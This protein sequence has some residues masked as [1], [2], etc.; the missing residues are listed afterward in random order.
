MSLEFRL[1]CVT[2][3]FGL[4][5]SAL[6]GKSSYGGTSMLTATETEKE[7]LRAM[8]MSLKKE[9]E[10]IEQQ[11]KQQQQQPP[12]QAPPPSEHSSGK[13][14]SLTA[15]SSGAKHSK[16]LARACTV[17]AVLASVLTGEQHS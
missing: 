1:K 4:V 14:L 12:H 2:D 5:N 8:R 16:L 7:D 11:L 17:A 9:T 10:E 3:E 13:R 15:L 6:R